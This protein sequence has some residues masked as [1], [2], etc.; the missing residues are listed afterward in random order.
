MALVSLQQRPSRSSQAHSGVG[1]SRK[2]AT[3]EKAE[4]E[5]QSKKTGRSE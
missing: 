3:P 1:K 5:G 2:N 4:E